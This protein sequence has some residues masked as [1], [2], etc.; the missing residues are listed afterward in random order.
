MRGLRLHRCLRPLMHLF[1]DD[2]QHGFITHDLLVQQCE[3]HELIGTRHEIPVVI[4]VEHHLHR[5][6]QLE[7]RVIERHF[8]FLRCWHVQ[9]HSTPCTEG[10]LSCPQASSS[11]SNQLR[12]DSVS[13]CVKVE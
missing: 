13:I 12:P 4:V 7:Q 11:F 6:V 1:H 9:G 3:Q 2:Q 8:D 5:L 10:F